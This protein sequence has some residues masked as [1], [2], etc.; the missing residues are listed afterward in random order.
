MS[1]GHLLIDADTLLYR[2]G[3]L[4]LKGEED[5]RKAVVQSFQ[6]TIQEC[7]DAYMRCFRTKPS[8]LIS[9]NLYFTSKGTSLRS[10]FDKETVYKEHRK[11][12]PKPKFIPEMKGELSGRYFL[13]HAEAHIGEAD[14]ALSIIAKQKRAKGEDYLICGCDKDLKQIPGYHYNYLQKVVSHISMEDANRFFFHQLL[15]GDKADNIPGLHGIG[16]VKANYIL[17]DEKDPDTLW[18]LVLAAYFSH[19]KDLSED[20][21]TDIIY[22]RANKLWLRRTEGEIWVPPIPCYD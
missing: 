8:A 21:I 16:P 22:E 17:G 15:T 12:T 1:M 20:E 4:S 5:Y 13:E 7:T 6:R 3:Y 19:Y 2:V 14:D 10:E 9:F 11:H 18:D